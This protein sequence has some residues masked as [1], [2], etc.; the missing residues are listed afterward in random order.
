MP[1]L[2]RFLLPSFMFSS[3][4]WSFPSRVL[5]FVILF[6]WRRFIFICQRHLHEIRIPIGPPK[7]HLRGL[8]DRLLNCYISSG[9]KRASY[10]AYNH[11]KHCRCYYWNNEVHEIFLR[12]SAFGRMPGRTSWLLN[13]LYFELND[14]L[15][16][17]AWFAFRGIFPRQSRILWVLCAL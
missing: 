17:S 2:F 11:C 4:S 3:V 13:A 12:F 15:E 8:F 5:R 1:Y 16:V 7:F 14:L 6:F 10:T 9:P